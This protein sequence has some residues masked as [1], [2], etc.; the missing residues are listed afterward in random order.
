MTFALSTQS[1]SMLHG[2]HA[3]LAKVVKEAILLSEVDF[4]V[5]EGMRSLARQKELYAAGKSKTMKSRHLTGHAVDLWA[6][7]DGKVSWDIAHYYTIAKAMKHAAIKCGVPMTWG[8]VWD[9]RL[10]DLSDSMRLEATAYANRM[11][12]AGKKPFVDGPHFELD[13]A[14]YA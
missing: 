9:R 11:K 10:G 3:D 5:G 4:K 6:I 12:A 8:V 7:V 2:V 1:L 13:A 14:T